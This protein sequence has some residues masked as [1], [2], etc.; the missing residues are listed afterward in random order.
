MNKFK[1][2]EKRSCFLI[3]T[4]ELP[5]TFILQLVTLA[6]AL[7]LFYTQSKKASAPVSPPV[8]QPTKPVQPIEENTTTTVTKIIEDTVIPKPKDKVYINDND[9]DFNYK[10]HIDYPDY[11]EEDDVSVTP[12]TDDGYPLDATPQGYTML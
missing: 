11:S 1:V 4:G 2:S 3:M 5:L 8:S 7:Y 6:M 12:L 9:L 10:R